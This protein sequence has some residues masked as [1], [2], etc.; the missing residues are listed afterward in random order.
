MITIESVERT[1]ERQVLAVIV[2]IGEYQLLFVQKAGKIV[3]Y[4][5]RSTRIGRAHPEGMR[6]PISDYRQAIKQVQG[7]FRER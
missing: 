1:P 7:I 2:A 6:I 4:K 5:R 3:E